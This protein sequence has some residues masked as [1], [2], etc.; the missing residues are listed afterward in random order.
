MNTTS[1]VIRNLG[2]GLV[3]GLSLIQAAQAAPETYG[4]RGTVR[5]EAMPAVQNCTTTVKQVWEDFASFP[6]LPRLRDINVLLRAVSG[7]PQTIDLQTDGFGYAEAWDEGEARYRGLI[8][9]SGVSNPVADGQS[10][11]VRPEVAEAIHE[12][13]EKRPK[14]TVA[15]GEGGASGDGASTEGQATGS[16]SASARSLPTRFYGRL[17]LEDPSRLGRDAGDIGREIVANILPRPG[18]SVKVTIEI[19][20]DDPNGFD[21]A[22]VRAISENA[23]ELGFSSSEFE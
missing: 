19:E 15:E 7:G 20:G 1:R 5:S 4:P 10:V 14:V 17:T 3:A 13:T 9:N 12:A 23:R 11:L 16:G 21:E 2:L 22:A 8:V 18:V 6:Y